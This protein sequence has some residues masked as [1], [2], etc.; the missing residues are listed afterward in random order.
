MIAFR[1]FRRAAG[2]MVGSMPELCHWLDL[3]VLVLAWPRGRY[4][5]GGGCRA[6]YVIAGRV[7]LEFHWGGRFFVAFGDWFFMQGA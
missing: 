6:V 4:A 3:G 2:A 7:C 5:G 1:E